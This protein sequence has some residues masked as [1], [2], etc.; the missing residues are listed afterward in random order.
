MDCGQCMSS[1]D[2]VRMGLKSPVAKEQGSMQSKIPSLCCVVESHKSSTSAVDP[3]F[4]LSKWRR[5]ISFPEAHEGSRDGA[6][7]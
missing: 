7:L 5:E 1:N 4:P 2:E 3:L 6:K